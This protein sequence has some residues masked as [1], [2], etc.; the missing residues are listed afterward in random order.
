MQNCPLQALARHWRRFWRGTLGPIA[1]KKEQDEED[2]R[3]AEARA[4]FWAELREGQ[5]QAEASSSKPGRAR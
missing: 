5:R 4:R 2:S 3:W 1:V